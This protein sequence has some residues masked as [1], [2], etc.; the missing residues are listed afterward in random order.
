MGCMIPIH[1]RSQG[2]TGCTCTP[3]GTKFSRRNLQGKFV[4]APPAHQVHPRQRKSQF[5][6]HCFA[7]GDLEVGVVRL[8]VFDRH[9]RATI[10]KGSQL[11]SGKKCTPSQ[12]KF[13]PRL[14]FHFLPYSRVVIP[15]SVP[16]FELPTTALITYDIVKLHTT[17]RP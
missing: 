12:T 1:R 4:N 9:L 5:L 3:W 15:I 16:L 2:C 17:P 6:G 11:F 7:G 13:W 14:C 10:K 8:V